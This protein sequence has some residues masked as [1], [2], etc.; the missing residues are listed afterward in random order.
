M[1]AALAE[2]GD[3]QPTERWVPDEQLIEAVLV[4]SQRMR[5]LSEPDRC[6]VVAGLRRQGLTAERIAD[7]LHC[8][9]RSVRAYAAEPATI[10]ASL[11]MAER[12]HFADTNRM[13]ASEITRLDTLAKDNAGA[14]ERYRVQLARL[15]ELHVMPGTFRCGCPRDRYNSYVDAKTGKTSCR[16]HR[17]LAVER[18]RQRKKAL[19]RGVVFIPEG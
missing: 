17:R 11:Y 2:D 1:T 6:W 15:V 18:H 9:L 8:S 10:L 14:A 13:S 4:G 12:E 16:E 19:A 3:D 5:E 7:L